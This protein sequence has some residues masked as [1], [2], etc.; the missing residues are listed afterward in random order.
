MF[1][2]WV[3]YFPVFLL[4]VGGGQC[5]PGQFTIDQVYQ[6]VSQT[7][8]VISPALTLA[9]VSSHWHVASS[10]YHVSLTPEADMFS[11]LI[12]VLLSQTIVNHV[13]S[14]GE[15]TLLKQ[16]MNQI[17]ECNRMHF[18][19]K[20]VISDFI[21]CNCQLESFL[22]SRLWRWI[23]ESEVAPLCPVSGDQCW[24]MSAG[25]IF[26]HKTEADPQD[27][28]Q[29]LESQDKRWRHTFHDN[30]LLVH[31]SHTLQI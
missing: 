27:L 23:Q 13:D 1:Q 10:A 30:I 24:D 16:F 11:S 20:A 17:F 19:C 12:L 5:L 15:R 22:V 28:D 2:F 8:Q 21:P 6:H 9:M 14:V 3:L 29:V 31:L 26:L 7:L 25:R 18:A 4:D